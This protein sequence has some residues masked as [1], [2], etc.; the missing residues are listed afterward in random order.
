MGGEARVY[1]DPAI[2]GQHEPPVHVWVAE[3]EDSWRYLCSRHEVIVD[4]VPVD[5][6]RS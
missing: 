1:D 5:R 3:A 2:F 6:V 4:Q